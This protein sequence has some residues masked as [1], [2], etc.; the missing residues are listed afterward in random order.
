MAKLSAEEL[1]RRRNL[2]LQPSAALTPAR[3][4][5]GW[6][7]RRSCLGCGRMRRSEGPG[8]RLCPGCRNWVTDLDDG[9]SHRLHLW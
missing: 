2:P 8:D 3:Q 1:Y 4:V 5:P 9:P 7:Q 6:P